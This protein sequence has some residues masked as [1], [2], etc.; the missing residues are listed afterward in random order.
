M[1]HWAEEQIPKALADL[2]KEARKAQQEHEQRH[3]VQ[4][5]IPN[6]TDGLRADRLPEI[7]QGG[8]HGRR[9]EEANPSSVAAE[10]STGERASNTDP[11]A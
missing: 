3:D 5:E 9:N 6:L 4:L 11:G 8:H 7:R 10:G 1:S 2:V